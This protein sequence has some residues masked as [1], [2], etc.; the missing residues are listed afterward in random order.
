[1]ET[2]WHRFF[3]WMSR[4]RF[5]G[6]RVLILAMATLFVLAIPFIFLFIVAPAFIFGFLSQALSKLSS[7]D[8]SDS[9]TAQA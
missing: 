3:D 7:R 1:M 9:R 2:R 5:R 8:D 6:K 4:S